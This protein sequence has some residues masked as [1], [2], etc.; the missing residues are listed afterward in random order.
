MIKKEDRM[1]SLKNFK[2]FDIGKFIFGETLTEQKKL[3]MLKWTLSTT[4]T[5][6]LPFLVAVFKWT[7]EKF[8]NSF[9][10]YIPHID[11]LLLLYAVALNCY[12]L[13]KELE[14]YHK[15]K[16][17]ER[18]ICIFGGI[19]AFISGGFYFYLIGAK[20]EELHSNVLIIIIVV[21][22]INLLLG[23]LYIGSDYV[24]K[25]QIVVCNAEDNSV[26]PQEK[27]VEEKDA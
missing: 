27:C 26:I 16:L 21:T 9:F 8:K 20:I 13:K 24:K 2:R 7:A 19:V 1:M 12:I 11:T 4:L 15:N 5:A 17:I 25:P 22:I 6:V 14:G 23:I 3:D 18:A 10:S